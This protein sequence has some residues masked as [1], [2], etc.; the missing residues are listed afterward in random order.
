MTEKRFYNELTDDIR[1]IRE[2]VFVAEQGFHDEFD[3]QDEKS[4]HLVVFYNGK[5]VATGR[6]FRSNDKDG[7]F[8]IG[9]VAVLKDYRNLHLG[10]KV[11]EFLEEKAKAEGA[12]KTE[13]SAQCRAQEFYIKCGY[14]SFGEVYYDQHCPHIHME[15]SL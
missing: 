14:K 10:Y 5:A 7:F 9:R 3:E 15:K 11:M 13:L 6:V 12:V 2:A 4:F 1:S 8:T